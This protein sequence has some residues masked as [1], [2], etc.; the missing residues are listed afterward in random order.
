MIISDVILTRI[1][2]LNEDFPSNNCTSV[3]APISSLT[4]VAARNLVAY[5]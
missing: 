1:R 2:L 3:T 4:T 5:L